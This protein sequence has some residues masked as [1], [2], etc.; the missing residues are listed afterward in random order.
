MG[1]TPLINIS[2][3]APAAMGGRQIFVKDESRNP[4]LSHK[5]RLNKYTVSA[6]LMEGAHTI[7]AASTGNH[8]VSAAAMA[9]RAGMNSIIFTTPDVSETFKAMLRAFNAKSIFVKSEERW[10]KM[11]ELCSD[12]GFYSVSNLT[13]SSHT[14][15]PWGAEGYKPIAYEIIRDLKGR[16]P[17]V[18]VVPT[19]YGELLFGIY[20]G[21]HEALLLGAINRVPKLVSVEPAARAPLFQAVQS[22][23]DIRHVEPLPTRQLGTACLVNS[24][25]A[26]VAIRESQGECVK[27][28]DT[29]AGSADQ[30]LRRF[31]LWFELSSCAGFAALDQLSF[32]DDG[33]VVLIAC[34]SG[35]K[36]PF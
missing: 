29:K 26:V 36:E 30:L 22:G 1:N 15:H 35:I 6:A 34:S 20:K 33:P 31:G 21:F 11:R 10:C 8:G 16:A 3:I 19:G 12:P 7:V 4:T 14:G 13:P 9:A 24:Y 2:K 18:V 27:V 32:T 5:D 23:C 17:S 25:R 28:D